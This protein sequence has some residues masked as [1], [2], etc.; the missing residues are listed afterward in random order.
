MTYFFRE[1]LKA[2][3]SFWFI[4]LSLTGLENSPFLEFELWT[5]SYGLFSLWSWKV[6]L[7][8]QL[9][10]LTFIWHILPSC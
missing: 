7:L 9:E 3:Q 8:M 2:K 10:A 4:L 5:K 6:I 1:K